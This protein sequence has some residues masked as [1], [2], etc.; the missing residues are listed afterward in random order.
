MNFTLRGH[1]YAS[2]RVSFFELKVENYREICFPVGRI[3]GY[4]L[5]RNDEN[6]EEMRK[7]I[8]RM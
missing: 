2:M 6:K 3:T 4:K 8:K 1:V 5:H 7:K